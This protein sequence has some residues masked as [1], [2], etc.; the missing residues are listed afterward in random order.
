MTQATPK[1]YWI[2]PSALHIELN[3]IGDPDYI[4]ASCVSGAQILVYVK[5][6]IGYDAGHNY[7]RW[8]LQAAPT[9]FNSHAEKYVY[10]A[11]PRDMTLTASAWIVFPSEVIDVY[12]KNEKEEQIG[13]E[14]YYYI[15]L[16]G[17]ITSSGDN[18]TV[19]RDWKQRIATGYLSSDEA[20]SAVGSETEWYNYS[21]VDGI[22]TLLKD[23]TMKDGTKFRKF[24]ANFLN[25]M[26]NGSL[27]FV[28]QG[29]LTGI[30]DSVST[31]NTSTDKIVTPDFVNN[32]SI[33][34]LHDDTAEGKITFKDLIMAIKGMKI[35]GEN[36]RYGIDEEANAVFND[37]IMEGILRVLSKVYTDHIE[38]RSD[39]YEAGFRGFSLHKTSNGRYRL[40]IDEL[41]VRIKAIF[42]EL[43]IRKLSFV[44]GNMELSAAGGEIYRVKPLYREAEEEPYAF[45]CWLAADDGTTRTRN[46]WKPG[47][48]AKCQT[49]N[50]D[51][52]EVRNGEQALSVNGEMITQNGELITYDDGTGGST[53]NKYYWRLV[54]ATGKETLEDGKQYDWIELSNER[55]VELIVDGVTF[56]CEG[57]DTVFD[58]NDIDNMKWHTQTNDW[59]EQGD[60]IV[61]EGSQTDPE[62]QHMIRLNTVGETAPSIEEFS[63]VGARDGISPWNLSKRRMTV[64]APRT[65]DIFVAKKFEI[66]TDSGL[67]TQIPTERG[68]YTDGM[69]CGYYDRVS[70]QGS[71]WLCVC[72]IGNKVNDTIY[73]PSEDYTLTDGSKIW[74]EQV[75]K[76]EQ[77]QQGETGLQGE[78]GERGDDG[79]SPYLIEVTPS[80]IILTQSQEDTNAF[81]FLANKVRY[82][83]FKGELDVTY[84]TR[85]LDVTT[86]GNCIASVVEEDDGTRYAQI[87]ALTNSP[88]SGYIDMRIVLDDNS[89]VVTRRVAYYVNYLGT[90]KQTIEND[91]SKSVSE[92]VDASIDGVNYELL[93]LKSNVATLEQSS[94]GFKQQVEEQITTIDGELENVQNRFSEIEQKSDEISLSVYGDDEKNYANPFGN[95]NIADGDL[96]EIP[97]DDSLV[98][99]LYEGTMLIASAKVIT[100]SLSAGSDVKMTF[101]MYVNGNIATETVMLFEEDL[102][103]VDLQLKSII[104]ENV[105]SLSFVIKNDTGTDAILTSASVIRKLPMTESLK[106]TGIDITNG[107]IKIDAETT[108]FSGD[109]NVYGTIQE[110]NKQED[111]NND[112]YPIDFVKNRSISVPPQ[113]LVFLP[114]IQDVTCEAGAFFDNEYTFNAYQK[115]GTNVTITAL[116]VEDIANWSCLSTK[117]TITG[118][119]NEVKETVALNE[120]LKLQEVFSN[121]Y[122]YMTLVCA[123][124]RL[125]KNDEHK[126]IDTADVAEV[127]LGMSISFDNQNY[128]FGNLH[129][130]F[131]VNG[132]M[133]RFIALMPGQILKL[134]SV[135]MY[136]EQYEAGRVHLSP[137]HGEPIL[138]W[139]VENASDFVPIHFTLNVYEG[140]NDVMPHYF[141]NSINSVSPIEGDNKYNFIETVFGHR[142]LEGRIWGIEG[143]GA[144]GTITTMYGSPMFYAATL[145]R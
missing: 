45:R 122:Q 5:D 22:V 119:G 116:P 37:A 46:W 140:A 145:L 58:G 125:L 40:E 132:A 9:V 20:I 143:D 25:V 64:L 1:D 121:T 84:N 75:S 12:G 81:D 27:S 32:R 47:D 117:L 51:G 61:Q 8:P 23:L 78:Q 141:Y 138:F 30:A 43:E 2:S 52:S 142:F 38:S 115:A 87:D 88:Q 99:K 54:T 73:P 74:I 62:R 55:Q 86:D 96:Y 144:T 137:N 135:I 19:Q 48:Q 67:K 80:N 118:N 112:F 108:E 50:I 126:Y 42:N 39:K 71:L 49:F 111:N 113:S 91:V 76:G 98:K 85:L 33:S 130:R 109:I 13:D 127:N 14:K 100:P 6:I 68:E 89:T 44:G 66:I 124:P 4:Q 82:K 10:A 97:V 123:D 21:S 136:G 16:Q 65:G 120:D 102:T 29:D 31:P 79:I 139:N 69:V 24:F 77:G 59:P 53:G 133:T 104:S 28:G 92:K 34:K 7:R 90:F 131:L 103:E 60:S 11:I 129:G 70:Y 41:L 105:E 35:G 56:T 17:V 114:M 106:R 107:T 3:A 57:M 134:K 95:V 94:E 18:G 101:T 15:N 26:P 128:F 63:N 36:S 93:V 83:V 110:S 72:K